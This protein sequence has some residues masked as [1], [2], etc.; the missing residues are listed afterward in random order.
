M[1]AGFNISGAGTKRVL[2]RGIGPALAGFGVPGTLVDPKL[3]IFG[4]SGSKIAEN[5]NWDASLATTFN[6][7]GAFGF[8]PNSKDAAVVLTLEA[9]RSYTV[10]VSGANSGTGEAMI[11][12]YELP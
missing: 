12:V 7:V 2:I 10:Q 5:D 3:E 4:S 9:G 11:E 8:S 6:S 1:I